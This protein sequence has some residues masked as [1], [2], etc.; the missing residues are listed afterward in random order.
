MCQ[1]DRLGWFH[2]DQP[3]QSEGSSSD[4]DKAISNISC[5]SSY[6]SSGVPNGA[7]PPPA[8]PAPPHPGRAPRLLQGDLPQTS[9]Q[10]AGGHKVGTGAGAHLG[11]HLGLQEEQK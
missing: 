8:P 6:L 9:G 2:T 7:P 4:D 10:Q 11:V 3:V 1:D 5:L